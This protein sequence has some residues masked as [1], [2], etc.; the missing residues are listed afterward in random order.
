[1][2]PDFLVHNPGDDVGVAIRELA[3]GDA[4]GGYLVGDEQLMIGLVEP[5]P[6]GHKFAL[7]DIA[8]GAGV[9]EYGVRIAVASTD[10]SA[11]SHAHV[12][13]LR[14][15]RWQTSIAS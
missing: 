8:N 5:V 13:N 14:S 15:V 4:R 10:I 7:R 11:G 3:P 9:T 12:H 6:L 2:A 1:M